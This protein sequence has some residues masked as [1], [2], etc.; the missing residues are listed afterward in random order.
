MKKAG[1]IG[2]IA[3]ALLI[4]MS[5]AFAARPTSESI[6]TIENNLTARRAVLVDVREDQETNR[7]YIDGAILVPLSLLD[8][9]KDFDEFGKVLAQRLPKKAVIYTYCAA[10]KRCTTAADILAKFGYDARPLK[11][12][13]ADLVKEG[14]VT[15]KPK[16]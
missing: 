11:H 10:G 7:G 8:E 1:V 16:K 15:A 6:D 13:F 14:F 3:L 5:I 2:G 9:G 12:G 4:T